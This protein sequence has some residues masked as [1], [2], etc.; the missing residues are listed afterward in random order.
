MCHPHKIF[1]ESTQNTEHYYC[2]CY[3]PCAVDVFDPRYSEFVYG[4]ARGNEYANINEYKCLSSMSNRKFKYDS[5]FEKQVP[6]QIFSKLS[7]SEVIIHL[8]SVNISTGIRTR[9]L[10]HNNP[11]FQHDEDIP[12]I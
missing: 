6:I 4:N 3:K 1:R 12:R 11:V 10:Y 9:F 5:T 2:S 8:K 7:N